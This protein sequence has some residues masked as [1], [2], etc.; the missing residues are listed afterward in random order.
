MMS[1]Q[2]VDGQLFLIKHLLILR[3]QITPFQAEFII[4][5]T[6]LDFSSTKGVFFFLS[7]TFFSIFI[8][9]AAL[10]FVSNPRDSFPNILA[11]SSHNSIL[12]LMLNGA[13]SVKELY[14]D[15]KK[16]VDRF[17][18]TKFQSFYQKMSF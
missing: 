16:D 15:S 3:E 9:D 2:I 6:Q 11:A 14:V 13:P 7:L 5:E 10:K 12:K 4:R 18:A 17:V 8:S 1:S